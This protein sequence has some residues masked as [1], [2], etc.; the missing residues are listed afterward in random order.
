MG[1]YGYALG[2]NMDPQALI[3]QA[4][5]IEDAG[6]EAAWSNEL[7][8]SPFV[9]LAAVASHTSNIKLGSSIAYGFTRSP[10]E[11]VITSLDL[12]AV[13][14]GRFIL[15]LGSGVRRLNEMW[16]GVPDYGRP[17]THLKECVRAIRAIIDGVSAGEPVRFEGE[18]YDID[19]RGWEG[20]HKPVN[21]SIPIYMAAVRDGML[22]AAGDVADG[23]LG[24]PMWSLQWVKEMVIPNIEKGLS[25]SGRER[26]DFEIRAAVTVAI[27][28]DK[29]Q[30]YRDSRGTPGFYTTIRTYQPLVNWHGYEEEAEKIREAF[31]KLQGFGDEVLEPITDEM[32]DTFVVVGTADEARARVAEFEEI[33][34]AVDLEVPHNF[35]PE[36]V[37]N[38]YE[39]R[40]FEVFGN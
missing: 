21:G 28:N 3:A 27:T 29:K 35:I 18:H 24:F 31:V 2:D 5:K 1:R 33:C 36:E 40:L 25:R 9:P 20:P 30:G 19:M 38:E 7:F 13:T 17:A 6:F 26:K 34:D 22:R 8:T 32:V 10:L 15:G 14:N 39:K 16:H 4:R 11:T 37:H 23:V 12:D